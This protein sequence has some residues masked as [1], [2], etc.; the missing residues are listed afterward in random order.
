MLKFPESWRTATLLLLLLGPLKSQ[1]LA[2]QNHTE[3]PYS[4]SENTLLLKDPFGGHLESVVQS[5][6]SRF[7]PAH[8][9]GDTPSS[10]IKLPRFRGSTQGNAPWCWACCTAMVLYHQGIQKNP[11]QIVSETLGKNCCSIFASPS[12][13]TTGNLQGALLRYGIKTLT[14]SQHHKTLAQKTADIIRELKKGLPT[15][16]ILR[17]KSVPKPGRSGAHSIVAYGVEGLNQ[18]N[19]RKLRLILYDPVVGSQKVRPAELLHYS[20]G[21]QAPIYHWSSTVKILP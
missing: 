1:A 20:N 13:W 6:P 12:C 8:P 7:F 2:S 10:R 5:W 15:V 3:L 11:C 18:P 19:P 17:E 16:L 9:E 21:P 14:E 4:L